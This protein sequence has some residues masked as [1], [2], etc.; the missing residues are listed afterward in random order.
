MAMG[1]QTILL[2][3][4]GAVATLTMNRPDSR[5]P[6]DQAGAAEMVAALAEVQADQ[7]IRVLIITGAGK[8]FCTGGDIK[9]YARTKPLEH[10]DGVDP[11]IELIKKCFA[12]R[13][14]IIAKVQGSAL[15][16]GAGVVSMCDFAIA[17]DD[18]AIGYPEIK[19]GLM[20]ATVAVLLA[21]QVPRR[22]A[23][24]LL[25]TGRK[26]DAEEAVAIGLFN[27]AVPRAK[28]DR[29]VDELAQTLAGQSPLA[30]RQLKAAFY[31]QADQPLERALEMAVDKFI[32]LTSSED[33][34]EGLSAF[35]EKRP[36]NWQGR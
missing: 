11:I 1:Y 21:R 5:N 27:E 17:A 8:I 9:A 14:P 4:D 10:L 28:L 34:M 13:M 2:D 36:P 12:L 32:G 18:V 15:G 22:T 29:R 23:V 6:L 3:R 24:D 20:P 19:L 35:M 30:L 31:G 26:L 25:F 33:A 16:G 7:A